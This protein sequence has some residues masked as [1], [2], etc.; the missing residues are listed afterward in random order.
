M[1]R[2][3]EKEMKIEDSE[4]K[5]CEWHFSSNS[6]I[7]PGVQLSAMKREEGEEKSELYS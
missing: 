1:E 3:V 2:G 7:V 5:K 4:E 6:H